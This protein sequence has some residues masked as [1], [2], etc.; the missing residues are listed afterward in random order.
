M[1]RIKGIYK[2]L[3]FSKK[4]LLTLVVIGI[5]VFLRLWKLNEVPISLFGDEIDVGL[6]A[7]SILTTGKDYFGNIYPVMF[8]SF[9][10][11]R[12]PM[13]LYMDV[14]FINIFGL[15]E[16]GVRLPSV[17]MGFASLILFYFLIKEL[18]DKKLAVVTTI[19]LIYS[20][21]HFNFSRQANDA[22]ILLPFI[23]AGTLFFIKGLKTYK[24]LIFSALCFSLSF[25]AYAISAVFTPIFAFILIAIYRKKVFKYSFKKLF[26]AGLIGIIIL[27][28]FI[29]FSLKGTTSRRFSHISSISEDRLM[30][31]VVSKRRWSNSFLTRAFYNKR[32]IAFENIFKNYTKS[33]S[34]SFLFSEG[35]PNM[36]QSIEGFGQLYHYDLVLIAIGL[37]SI[38][39]LLARDE[40]GREKYLLLITWLLVAPLSSALTDDGGTHASRL[41]LMLPPLIFISAF[42]FVSMAKITKN[43]KGKLLIGI[44]ALIMI[45]NITRFVHRY[46]VIW[47]NESWRFWQSGFEETVS[48]AK[49]HD[50]K[51]S[52]IYFNNTYEPMFPRF[53]FW[54]QYDMELFQS[55]FQDDKHIDDIVPGFDGFKLGDKYYFGD[56]QKPVE[57]LVN[58]DY[59]IVASGEKD[60]TN[61]EIFNNPQLKLLKVVYSPTEIPIFYIFTGTGD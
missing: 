50:I 30:Q 16:I 18:F 6:Q 37:W 4:C 15:N 13:Q 11:Y 27:L 28:P 49:Q 14:P 19:F 22:G 57:N 59:L 2:E 29:N 58:K 35:D 7:N 32:T 52:R 45:V 44:F 40:K 53:L 1:K 10:E 46:F 23:I 8:R 47:P 17:I 12:Y 60:I 43:M 39:F 42:G 3:K 20:P 51:F 24:Y 26:L 56:I 9:S 36:R 55:Q 34:M 41:I 33:F 25:Y 5:G 48:Y 54:Y 61:P 38:I 21:W 31:E